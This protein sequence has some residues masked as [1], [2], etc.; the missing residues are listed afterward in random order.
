MSSLIL[1]VIGAIAGSA[2]VILAESRGWFK[3][4]VDTY[5]DLV[6]TTYTKYEEHKSDNGGE[7]TSESKEDSSTDGSANTV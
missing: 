4:T 1:L 3:A 2:F 6:D 5:K 7:E